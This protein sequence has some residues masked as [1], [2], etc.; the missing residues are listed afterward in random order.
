MGVEQELTVDLVRVPLM[1]NDIEYLVTRFFD[2]R[3]FSLK[4][5]TGAYQTGKRVLSSGCVSMNF[6]VCLG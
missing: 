1:A 5:I 2:V 3:S 4:T 6:H